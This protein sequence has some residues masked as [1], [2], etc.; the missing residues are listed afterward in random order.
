MTKRSQFSSGSENISRRQ[1][2]MPRIGTKGTSGQRNGRATSGWRRRMMS[3][4]A[5]TITNAS[6]VP[7]LVN[8]AR[9]LSGMSAPISPTTVPVRIVAFQG[10]DDT[11]GHVTTWIACLLGMG[12]DRIETDVGEKHDGG[13]GQY[14]ERLSTRSVLSQNSV[15]EETDAGVAV[16]SEGVP[17]VRIDVKNA[18]GD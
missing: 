12:R 13:A 1:R 2:A 10:A 16:G 3:T 5:Q 14:P 9:I 17:I 15:A 4:A 8:S 18:D 11:D 6:N 7:M